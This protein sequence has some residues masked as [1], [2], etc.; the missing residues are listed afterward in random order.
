MTKN[1]S[2]TMQKF[3]YINRGYA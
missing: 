2:K 1:H 3:R